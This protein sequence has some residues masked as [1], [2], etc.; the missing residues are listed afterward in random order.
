[1]HMDVISYIEE[2]AAIRDAM[3]KY[4]DKYGADG[5]LQEL[6]TMV[7]EKAEHVET[8][9]ADA[10]HLLRTL[11]TLSSRIAKCAD[12]ARSRMT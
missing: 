8:H 10:P 5:L 4:A 12:Y 3:E 1:M 11:R 9:W 6:S 2:S 7:G